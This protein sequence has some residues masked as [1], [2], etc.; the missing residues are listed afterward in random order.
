MLNLENKKR[1]DYL[2]KFFYLSRLRP[3]LHDMIE[4]K[5]DKELPMP[6]TIEKK[7]DPL[8][9][10]GRKEGKKETKVTIAKALLKKGMA[11]DVITDV[12]GLDKDEVKAL[13][14]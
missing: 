14:K 7:S 6:F 1:E 5:Q 11:I 3:K 12:T 4:Q 9:K 8:Y 13:Q 2:R 10:S